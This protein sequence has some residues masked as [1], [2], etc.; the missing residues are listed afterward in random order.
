MDKNKFSTNLAKIAFQ[1]YISSWKEEKRQWAMNVQ[2]IVINNT[3]NIFND[4]L[5]ELYA[6]LLWKIH[7][8]KIM[9]YI[10]LN[11]L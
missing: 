11:Y 8:D 5:V 7:F 6:V 2:N 4:Y 9:G 1:K 3:F 10:R